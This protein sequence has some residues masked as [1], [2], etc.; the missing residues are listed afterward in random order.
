MKQ[1]DKRRHS[2]LTCPAVVSLERETV[3]RDPINYSDAIKMTKLILAGAAVM[4]VV[5]FSAVISTWAVIYTSDVSGE[6]KDNIERKRE[7]Y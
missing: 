5:V 3:P 1:R 4:T 7:F 6:T 2:P